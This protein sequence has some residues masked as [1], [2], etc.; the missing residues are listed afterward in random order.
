MR[1]VIVGAGQAGGWVARTLRDRAFDGEVVLLG[2]EM[3]PPYERPSL[4]KQLLSGKETKPP[5]VLRD[6]ELETG[7]VQ[8]TGN[9]PVTRINT[10]E[11]YIECAGGLQLSYDR[12]VLT[13]G[14][15]ARI[16]AIPGIDLPGVYSLRT[17]QDCA[18]ISSH[19]TP[20]RKMLVIG[21]GWIGL[22]VAATARIREMEVTVVEAGD[23]LC[24]RSIPAEISDFLLKK[25]VEAGVSI[26]FKTSIDSIERGNDH[27]IANIGDDRLAVDIIVVGVGLVP[28]SEL[29]IE[30]GLQVDNGIVVDERGQTS[31]VAIYAAG[32]IT[33][34]PNNWAGKR[35]RLESWANAQNQGI[36]VGRVLSGEEFHYDEIP[37]FWSDQ[38]DVNLQ[39][40]GIPQPQC[41]NVFRGT[42]GESAFTVYQFLG[43]RLEAVISVNNARD[44]KLAKRWMK[45][46]EYP[47][48]ATLADTQ[49][50]LEKL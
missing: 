26:R 36:A 30:A 38:Y 13:M 24:A 25:H 10:E 14:G 2:A 40:I 7:Q 17:V 16:P 41:T 19:L 39:V 23:R 11:K 29:A 32:D 47:S 35:M 4:S 31:D 9:C 49:V 43:E 22:E 34:H 50:R 27:L 20:G 45:A 12:L 42:V 37:W 5:F 46:G 8:F 28:N 33:N 48:A 1:I 21:G 44:I 3:L 18:N 15:R 6:S